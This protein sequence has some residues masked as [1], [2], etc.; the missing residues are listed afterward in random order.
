MYPPRSRTR[1][2]NKPSNKRRRRTVWAWIN[3]SLLLMIAAL[4]TYAFLGDPDPS[5][6][7]PPAAAIFSSPSPEQGDAEPE[8]TISAQPTP[9]PSPAAESSSEPSAET[10]PK[11]TPV[12]T[13]PGPSL[14]PEASSA[15][16][17]TYDPVDK[18]ST[19]N[20]S[21][22]Q[23]SGLPENAGKTVKLS[24]A[25]DVIFSGKAGEILQQ[26]GY[27]YSYADLDGMFKKDDLSILNLETPITTGGVG[28]ANKQF[29]FKGEPRALD[30]LK[31][32]GVDAVNLAN[33][34]TLDQG[35]EGLLDTLNHLNKRGIPYVGGGAN[36]AEAYSAKYFERNGIRIALLGFTRVLPA[37]EW[38]AQAGKPGVASVYDSAEA[39]KV[40]AG[41][42]KKADLVIVMVHWGKE[43]MEQYDSVQQALGRSFIDAGADLV[44]GGHPHVLQGIEPYKGKWIAYSTGN[45]IFT[46]SLTRAT[47]DTAVFQAECSAQGQCSMKLSPMSAE[48]AKPVPM[49]EVDGQLLLHKVQSLSSGLVKIGNDGNVVQVVK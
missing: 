21:S 31:A 22:S 6:D 11:T 33:N 34:H 41:A 38:Q 27:D 44:M 7:P 46:R 25:G 24:F 35:E 37:M 49:N 5:G 20:S 13:E 1:K 30:S 10:T 47:W 18:G 43:R 28:A 4:L 15:P 36:A 14:A 9:E 19:R 39:L 32:A 2:N 3:V 29:V 48:L 12:P 23:I 8:P 40:I 45:F 42:R 16:E 26:K 17:S